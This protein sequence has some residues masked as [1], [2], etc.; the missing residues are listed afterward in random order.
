MSSTLSTSPRIARDTSLAPMLAS[1]IF[2]RNCSTFS[3]F[4]T[5]RSIAR[6]NLSSWAF[7]DVTSESSFSP[8]SLDGRDRSRSAILDQSAGGGVSGG[9]EKS[10]SCRVSVL[11]CSRPLPASSSS[12]SPGRALSTQSASRLKRVAHFARSSG[13]DPFLIALFSS[14]IHQLR[15]P[16]RPLRSGGFLCCSR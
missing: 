8:S 12:T 2:A 14:Q 1:I 9:D 15:L 7:V 3:Y 10:C 13:R 5:G 11:I 4:T 6:A 16:N